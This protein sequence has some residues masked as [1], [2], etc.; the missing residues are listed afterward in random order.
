M[1]ISST[2]PRKTF[3]SATALAINQ[4]CC[5]D[6]IA[7]RIYHFQQFKLSAIVNSNLL[8][9]IQ[10]RNETFFPL[11]MHTKEIDG[12]ETIN[13]LLGQFFSPIMFNILIFQ[14]RFGECHSD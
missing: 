12:S 7:S 8:W 4:S 13:Y 14:A 6:L 1:L 2:S 11:L 3:L 5:C 10:S 9:K